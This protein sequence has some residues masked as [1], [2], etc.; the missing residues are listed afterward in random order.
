MTT[1]INQEES[2]EAVA[3]EVRQ[4]IGD[5][6]EPDEPDEDPGSEVLAEV[7]T[8]YNTYVGAQ[9]ALG[10][11]FKGKNRQDRQAYKEAERRYHAYD[12]AINRALRARERDEQEALEVYKKTV[13]RAVGRAA[14]AY[15]DS[16]KEALRTCRRATQQA[17]KDSGETSEQM[18][19]FFFGDRQAP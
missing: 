3:L 16:L 19:D 2:N 11:A 13:E 1:T 5:E 17:W 14:E 9:K 6:T 15:R 12:D 4:T 8:A 18:E 10:V 7:P